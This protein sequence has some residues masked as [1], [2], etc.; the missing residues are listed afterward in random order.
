M[1]HYL[2]ENPIYDAIIE[3]ILDHAGYVGIDEID[4]KCDVILRLLWGSSYDT[5]VQEWWDDANGVEYVS[6]EEVA[7]IE[8]DYQAHVKTLERLAEVL[9]F[10]SY[11]LG[12]KS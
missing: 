11:S 1:K 10:K 12:D 2:D 8:N 7:E 3:V 6:L 5:M 4:P 9:G